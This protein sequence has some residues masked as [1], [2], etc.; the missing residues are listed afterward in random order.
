[1]RIPKLDPTKRDRE[2]NLRTRQQQVQIVSDWLFNARSHRDMD[3]EILGLDPDKSRGWQSM[4]VLHHMGLK[5]PFKG[6]FRNITKEEAIALLE[7]D[8]QDIQAVI[9]LLQ[10]E[11]KAETPLVVR[12]SRS[13]EEPCAICHRELPSNLMI[14]AYIKPWG[15]CSEAERKSPHAA[16]PVCKIGCDDFFENGY[17]V[18][19]EDGLVW[20]NNEMQYPA[21]LKSVLVDVLG[22]ECTHFNEETAEFFAYR[23]DSLRSD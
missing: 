4:N 17:I 11:A 6:L 1:M 2:F 18:V 21:T 7:Q 13:Q 14:A 15:A 5:E 16:M 8:A 19:E 10:D 3:Q 22:N 20:I 23:R 9:D 12:D